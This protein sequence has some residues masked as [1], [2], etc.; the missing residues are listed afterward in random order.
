MEKILNNKIAIVTGA[1][2]GIGKAIALKLGRLGVTVIINY[3][4]NTERA[5]KVVSEIENVGGQAFLYQA[6]LSERGEAVKMFD[7]I[8]EKHKTVDIL[9]NNASF[10][11]FKKIVDITEKEFDFTFALNVKSLFF[12]CKQA[13]L[14]MSQNGRIIN[15]SSSSTKRMVSG[16]SLY[17]ATKGA[18][19]QLTKVLSKELGPKGITVNTVS[20]GFTDT[21]MLRKG[22]TQEDLNNLAASSAFGRLGQPRDIANAVALLLADEASWITGQNICANGGII[23]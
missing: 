12:L 20:P 4:K 18:V 6:D 14:K 8:L 3:S 22:R 17:L 7:K 13:A 23:A 16:F 9:I 15:I 5:E 11:P 19:E 2:R 10:R 21:E 1:S